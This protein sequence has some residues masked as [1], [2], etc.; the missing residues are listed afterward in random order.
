M[1][2][3][4]TQAHINQYVQGIKNFA[5]TYDS[6]EAYENLKLQHVKYKTEYIRIINGHRTI[7]SGGRIYWKAAQR[8]FW[9][10]VFKSDPCFKPIRTK[11]QHIRSAGHYM[12]Y[13]NNLPIPIIKAT[14]ENFGHLPFTRF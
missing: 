3:V 2:T 11:L 4:L 5:L 12:R 10:A 9:L 13:I 6:Q 14:L 1:S 8:R 7:I